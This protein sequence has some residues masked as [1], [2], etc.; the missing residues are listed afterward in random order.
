MAEAYSMSPRDLA[1]RIGLQP[2]TRPLQEQDGQDDKGRPKWRARLDADGRELVEVVTDADGRAVYGGD[3]LMEVVKLQLR[4]AEAVAPY[5]AQ[6]LPQAVE[7]Q[8]RH[9]FTMQVLGVSLPAR[10][11]GAEN[12]GQVEGQFSVVLPGKSDD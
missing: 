7:V 1:E 12:P 2:L 4:M 3:V 9:D 8:A 11:P 10:A 5:V 6:R